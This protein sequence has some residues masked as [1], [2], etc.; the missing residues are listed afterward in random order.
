MDSGSSP[1]PLAARLAA[2]AKRSG[3]DPPEFSISSAAGI[4]APLS[5]AQV[6]R[7]SPKRTKKNDDDGRCA[8]L[9]GVTVVL[10]TTLPPAQTKRLAQL[11]AQVRKTPRWPR[12][13]ANF[14][15]FL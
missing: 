15:L 8:A 12:S 7:K 9:T 6:A 5:G 3:G 10:S 2:R 1:L 11:L 14:S 4:A 13:W